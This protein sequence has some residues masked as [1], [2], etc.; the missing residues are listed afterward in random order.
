[1]NNQRAQDE[2]TKVVDIGYENFT[3]G[4]IHRARRETLRPRR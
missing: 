4:V 3:L 1:M 2:N